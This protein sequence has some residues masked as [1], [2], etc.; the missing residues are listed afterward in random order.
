MVRHRTYVA[1]TMPPSNQ[2][3]PRSRNPRYVPPCGEHCPIEKLPPEIL[4]YIIELGTHG[5]E[6]AED[7]EIEE[8][9]GDEE[10][11]DIDD[12]EDENM[13]M[14]IPG[15]I[16]G[17][18]KSAVDAVTEKTPKLPF[19]VRMSHVC[20]RWRE[21]AIQTPTLWTT[22]DFSE[23]RPWHKTREWI[24]RSKESPLDIFID[25]SLPN[26]IPFPNDID[27]DIYFSDV[28]MRE[29]QADL[30][31]MLNLVIDQA[32][33]WRTFKL[34][35]D[36]YEHMVL[37]LKRLEQWPAN[38]GAP[39]LRTLVL[40]CH[41]DHDDSEAETGNGDN[42]QTRL[43]MPF[44]GHAPKLEKVEL[45]GVHLGWKMFIPLGERLSS[46][47]DASPSAITKLTE[48]ELAYHTNDVRP[49]YADFVN[50]VRCSPTL[51]SLK[52]LD[53][54][55]APRLHES[56]AQPLFLPN[57]RHLTLGFFEEDYAIS[58]LRLLYTP[59]LKILVLDFDE[60]DYTEFVKVL[61]EKMNL[62]E[63]LPSYFDVPAKQ[64]HIFERQTR[65][66]N[67]TDVKLSGLPCAETCAY[68]FYSNCRN[69]KHLHLDS[70]FLPSTFFSMLA[71]D[72][73]EVQF[74]SDM[75]LMDAPSARDLPLCGRLESLSVSGV[76]ARDLV[77]LVKH[78]KASGA[79]IRELNLDSD[80]YSN[81]EEEELD[82]LS[83]HVKSLKFVEFSD[84]EEDLA[85]LDS[86][87]EVGW[88]FDEEDMDEDMD[89]DGD[90]DEDMEDA[91]A[92]GIPDAVLGGEDYWEGG[93]EDYEGEDEDDESDE[94]SL[95]G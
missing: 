73:H 65:L 82:W 92:L 67:V 17:K 18:T 85:I 74:T 21:L 54:G 57:L 6:N 15:G 77:K 30:G 91:D 11:E 37:A 53:S 86:D 87:E 26:D 24:I 35:V 56:P 33:R 89:E 3:Q 64:R 41:E 14:L 2:G 80:D 13:D 45:W 36:A 10:Y 84:D 19:P 22:L 61:T 66:S 23:R 59:A 69:L 25:V 47:L 44:G 34:T 42:E 75:Q 52:L 93:G 68:L 9:D 5:E 48:L 32:Y 81:N 20:R 8:D 63:P 38:P 16:E 71:N 95:I 51:T 1:G 70:N 46:A 43:F 60:G 12:S 72:F 4:Q 78:R 29:A 31:Y 28:V 79:P 62:P 55:P 76:R 50:I 27:S 94:D 7:W 39:V 83:K 49:S 90:D 40:N 58:L 88:E